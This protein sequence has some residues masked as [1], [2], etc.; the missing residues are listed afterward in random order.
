[1]CMKKVYSTVV[2]LAMMFV[3]SC[4]SSCSDDDEF[5]NND[6]VGQWEIVEL[7]NGEDN[8]NK[9]KKWV[10][11]GRFLVYFWDK[12]DIEGGRYFYLDANGTWKDNF[13]DHYTTYWTLEGKTLTTAYEILE[14]PYQITYKVIKLTSSEMILNH[15]YSSEEKDVYKE[16]SKG[17]HRNDVIPS[18]CR[19]SRR[20]SK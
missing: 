15:Q 10:V 2:M 3:A 12:V 8:A 1:M 6:A 11:Y 16:K 9:D 18:S 20:S 7:D 13:A 17:L 14:E 5:N 19:A 4:F